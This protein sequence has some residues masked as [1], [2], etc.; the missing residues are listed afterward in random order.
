[1]PSAIDAV[2]APSNMV[3]SK[4]AANARSV[5]RF[6]LAGLSLE[7]ASS[8]RLNYYWR[9]VAFALDSSQQEFGSKHIGDCSSGRNQT[10]KLGCFPQIAQ[11]N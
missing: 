11:A 10:Q 8:H 2:G 4:P 5:S 9:V 1:M 3:D 6:M 7:E